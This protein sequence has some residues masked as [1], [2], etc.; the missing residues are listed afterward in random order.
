MGNDGRFFHTQAQ[1]NAAYLFQFLCNG[2]VPHGRGYVACCLKLFVSEASIGANIDQHLN[3]LGMSRP[4]RHHER[5]VA[6]VVLGIAHRAQVQEIADD[7]CQSGPGGE[8]QR[9]V[10]RRGTAIDI[11][12]VSQ[13]NRRRIARSPTL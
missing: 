7:T 2:R 10:A 12:L 1:L 3:D 11:C 9:R 13:Q 6:L 4:R 8:D 5:C